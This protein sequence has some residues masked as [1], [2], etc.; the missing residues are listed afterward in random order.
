MPRRERPPMAGKPDLRVVPPGWNLPE[1]LEGFAR[2][3]QD[4]LTEAAAPVEFVVEGLIEDGDTVLLTGE[5]KVSLKT[6]LTLDLAI[7][8]VT[9]TPWLGRKVRSCAPRRALILS[10]ETS[11]PA[12]GRR[13]VALCR[14]RGLDPRE[15]AEHVLISTERMALVPLAEIDRVA[16][17]AFT[18]VAIDGLKNPDNQRRAQLLAGR[19][20]IIDAAKGALGSNL[21]RYEALLD[22]G[23]GVWGFIGIDT[24]RQSLEGDENSS[25]DAARYTAAARELA[26]TLECV[27]LHT[28]H[29]NKG[30]AGGARSAR[31]STELTAGP[32]A[33]FTIDASGEWPTMSFALRNHESPPPIGYRLMTSD[34]GV[35]FEVLDAARPSK[36]DGVEDGEVLDALESMS[37]S[38]VSLNNVRVLVSKARGGKVGSKASPVGVKRALDSLVARGQASEVEIK[39]GTSGAFPGWRA[40]RDRSNDEP[41]D[42]RRKAGGRDEVDELFEGRNGQ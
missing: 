36:A 10:S 31:G 28:H 3:G 27:G 18:R 42:I 6:W 20:R 38:A 30:N 24:L 35:V 12:M 32:D 2:G 15:V 34:R 33:I 41:R 40:G 39:G 37:P 21:A 29:T 26:R 9:G 25:R 7:A 8:R 5:E 19:G 23:P 17:S 4:L 14:G 22:S 16:E 13:F 11:F 1:G